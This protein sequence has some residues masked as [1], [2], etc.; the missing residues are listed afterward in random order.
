MLNPGG[1]CRVDELD[2]STLDQW[3]LNFN[4]IKMHS[5]G[6]TAGSPEPA[7][8]GTAQKPTV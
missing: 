7:S 6:P 5:P 4:G 2:F 8:R 1:P 3:F